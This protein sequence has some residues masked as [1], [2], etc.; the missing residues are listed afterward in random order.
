MTDESSA[1]DVWGVVPA[2]GLSRRMGFTKQTAAFGGS[3]PAA[4]VAA[5]LL[6]AGASGVVVV[7]RT[8]LL[9]ALK[10]PDDP[11][12]RTVVNDVADS[13]MID[14][15]RI[16]MEAI[17]ASTQEDGIMVIPADMPSVTIGACRRCIRAFRERPS[18]IVIAESGG[19]T[20]HPIIFSVALGPT[21]AQLDAGLSQLRH[22]H[23]DRVH[24]VAVDDPGVLNDLDTPG[25]FRR[26][27]SRLF[28]TP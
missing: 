12:L 21:I 6:E 15:I 9:E 17:H 5:T 16:G 11:Q 4:T 2:A 25:D 22:R 3:T 10:L 27:V 19:R 14:S 18:R 28:R 7:T 23:P 24:F 26:C 1:I 8:E 20:G 13:E